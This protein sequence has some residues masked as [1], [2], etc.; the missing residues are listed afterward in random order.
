ML[1]GLAVMGGAM[2]D[3]GSSAALASL[4]LSSEACALT[5]SIGELTPDQA[6]NA[7]IIVAT[8]F[9]DSEEN[10]RAAQIAVMV[11]YTESSLQDLGPMS[12]NDGSL[13]LF[14]QR[15]SQGWG[16]ASEEMDPPEATSMF[17]QRLLALPRWQS[18]AP[19]TA[20]QAVQRSATADGRNYE[21]HWPLAG[22]V[23]ASA[24][25]NGNLEGGCGQG[26][27]GGLAGSPS[28]HGL[29]AGYTI[30]AGTPPG[31]AQAV[32]F[33][34]GQLG[35]R[36]VWGGA[37]PAAFDCSGLTMQAWATAGVHLEHYTV[38]QLH[39]GQPVP[40]L[41]IMAGDLVLVPGSDAPGP[42][43]PGHVG[44]YLGDGLVLSAIDPQMGIAV[45]TWPAFVSGGLDGVVDPAPGL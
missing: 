36:Y 8:T 7:D 19:W 44:I 21:A 39:E 43:L 31:H 20:A 35:K 10:P 9:A 30:P 11:A 40:I 6:Q 18:V 34:L 3:S 2:S 33:A 5:G 28:A 1:L 12:G 24:L 27:P 42:G 23:L 22:Q 26:L 38:D 16:T 45:Q 37:G 13:G 25:R 41:T 29:P 32:G 17:V 4:E 15:V 14:Q